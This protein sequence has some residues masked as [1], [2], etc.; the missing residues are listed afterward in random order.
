MAQADDYRYV[1]FASRRLPGF[2][3]RVVELERVPAMMRQAGGIDCFSSSFRFDAKLAEH[4]A[5]HEGSVAAYA[6]ACASR[7]VHL[8]ID[9]GELEKALGTARKL[10][11][12]MTD[13]WGAT[14]ESL[15][16]Y[17]SGSKGFHLGIHANVFGEVRP[18]ERLPDVVHKVVSRLVQQ[19]RVT[20]G[21]VDYSVH[22]RLS[23][24]RS[25][26]TQHSSSGLYKVPL[27]LCELMSS[28]VAAIRELAQA[29]REP[30]FADATG[31]V[32]MYDVDPLPDAQ[33]LYLRCLDETA[34]R[35]K[36]ELPSPASFLDSGAISRALCSAELVLYHEGVPS[37]ARSWTTLRLASRFRHAGYS[38]EQAAELLGDWNERNQPPMEAA[39]VDRIVGAAYHG[40]EYQFGCGTGN[41]DHPATQLIYDACPYRNRMECSIYR[42]FYTRARALAGRGT[43]EGTRTRGTQCRGKTASRDWSVGAGIGRAGWKAF[44]TAR[45]IA[46]HGGGRAVR[47]PGGKARAESPAGRVHHRVVGRMVH[48]L[49]IAGLRLGTHRHGG[50]AGGVH[51]R[52]VRGH[53]SREHGAGAEHRGG[54][55]EERPCGREEGDR[56][57][58]SRSGR[59]GGGHGRCVRRVRRDERGG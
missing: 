23:L 18:S 11:G 47:K 2:R 27:T 58:R 6:G 22:R 39:E 43:W 8:D 17:F 36:R 16:S 51:P 14:D 19:A 1:E 10:A 28:D 26:N 13:Y 38:Q 48:R 44:E 12:Y 31:L 57:G 46:N 56:P 4:V 3:N 33:E 20:D 7:V 59:E 15:F 52:P 35:P 30:G 29:P 55:W 21:G 9:A 25:P 40:R 42:E 24:L 5:Q 45:G 34:A 53:R 49:L 50:R 32:P 37:G 41:G 54:R